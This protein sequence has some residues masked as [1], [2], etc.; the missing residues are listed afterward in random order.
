MYGVARDFVFRFRI[1]RDHA[2]RVSSINDR[3][4][5]GIFT[6]IITTGMW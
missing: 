2:V 3:V 1:L 4:A 6:T 5:S